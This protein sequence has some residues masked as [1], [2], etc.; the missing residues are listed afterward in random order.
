MWDRGGKHGEARMK[1]D[2]SVPPS[3]SFHPYTPPFFLYLLLFLLL[4]IFLLL[5]YERPGV[6]PVS[7]LDK[8]VLRRQLLCWCIPPALASIWPRPLTPTAETFQGLSRP[9][10]TL[11]QITQL[12]SRSLPLSCPVCNEQHWASLSASH[13]P[14][15][16]IYISCSLC[17]ITVNSKWASLSLSRF[18]TGGQGGYSTAS[19]A[20][21]LSIIIGLGP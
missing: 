19:A 4:L 7:C 6:P 13:F 8:L 20:K 2:C 11:Q 16:Y 18:R 3:L 9:V 15:I 1:T 12:S 17:F 5:L 10:F 21:I 14:P